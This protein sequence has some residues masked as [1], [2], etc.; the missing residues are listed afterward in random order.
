MVRLLLD[1]G[2]DREKA[3]DAGDT[4]LYIACKKGHLDVARLLL[5][6]ASAC[7]SPATLRVTA[8]Q[9]SKRGHLAPL[10]VSQPHHDTRRRR[11]SPR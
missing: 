9:R 10:H 6:K 11:A 8:S 1:A 5:P 3:E 4:P 7:R 2:A